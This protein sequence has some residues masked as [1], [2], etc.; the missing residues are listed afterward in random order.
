MIDVATTVEKPTL[1]AYGGESG[2]HG[3]GVHSISPPF[4]AQLE[5][6]PLAMGI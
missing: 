3:K 4:F 6:F 2:D 5:K 1:H